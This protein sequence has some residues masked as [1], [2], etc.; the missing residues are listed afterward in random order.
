MPAW[1]VFVVRRLASSIVLLLLL[2]LI[3]FVVFSRIPSNP[4]AFLIDLRY[5]TPAQVQHARHV[6]GADKPIFVQYGRFVWRALHGD[7]GRS[8]RQQRGGF[9]VPSSTGT[10]VAGQVLRAG[11]VTGAIA[12]GG[13]ILLF[14]VSVPLG[15]LAASRPR[16]TVDRAAAGVSMFGISTHPLV[17]ALLLQL[18][19]A[20]K[21]RLLPQTG[22]CDFFPKSVSAT[23]YDPAAACSGPGGWAEH[24]AIPW[25]VFALFFVALYS[26]MVRARMLEVL[27]QPYIR[28]ARAKGASQRRVMFRHALPNTALPIITMVAMDIGTAVGICVY[29]EAVFRMPGLGYTTIQSMGGAGL[30]LPMLVGI[31]LFTGT[32]IIVLNLLVDLIAVVLDPTI[33]H[34]PRAG[35]R[36]LGLSARTT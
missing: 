31:T 15:M 8:Y 27:D 17:V 22:Y 35:R 33:R 24:L 32:V 23:S 5:A 11:A 10:P 7:L 18:F 30:D 6:L 16:S 4:A 14:L 2:T 28:T 13:A 20:S 34:S 21:W 19:L 25:I 1:A 9:T 36:P 3:T 12:F 26:R 29:I